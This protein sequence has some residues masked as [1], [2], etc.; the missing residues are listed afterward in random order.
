MHSVSWEAN[1]VAILVVVLYFSRPLSTKE[2]SKLKKKNRDGLLSEVFFGSVVNVTHD[3]EL[4]INSPGYPPSS[5]S[6][7]SATSTNS[8]SIFGYDSVRYENH[9]NGNTL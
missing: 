2:E 5:P 1:F 9:I 4:A 6:V 7:A 3:P 8:N